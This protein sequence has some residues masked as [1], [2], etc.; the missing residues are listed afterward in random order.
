MSTPASPKASTAGTGQNRAPL[1][2]YLYD[3]AAQPQFTY[4]HRWRTGD[5]AFWDNRATWHCALDDCYGHRRIM[6]RIT[7]EGE[8]LR[9]A[10]AS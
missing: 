5:V 10:R 3:H 1:L 8:E 6:H 2:D 9:P 7:L 4:R